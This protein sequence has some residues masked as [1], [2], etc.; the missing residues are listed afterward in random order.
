MIK[1]VSDS[2]C[3][4][5]QAEAKELNVT[6]LPLKILFGE[7]EYYDGVTINHQQFYNMLIES[8][9]FPKT[10]LVSPAAFEEAFNDEDEIICLT[11]TSKLSGTYQS[12]V[13]AADGR[14]NIEVIDSEYVA[15]A[16][17]NLVK[18]ACKLRDEGKSFKEIVEGVKQGIKDTYVVALIETLEYLKKGGR[19][20]A[21]TAAIGSVLSIKPVVTIK[22]GEV[23]IIGKARGSKNATNLLREL[24]K[25]AG[26]IDFDRPYS[27]AYSGLDDTML[28][29]YIVDSADL[30]EG[31]TDSI[32]MG[33]IGSAIGTHAGPGAIAVSFFKK[34]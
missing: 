27:V 26:S 23:A 30:W 33:V 21:A 24:V 1:I 10:S 34:H 18:L 9:E 25:Q 2:G 14:E 6:V 11:V 19:I 17:G 20:S 31:H 13:I 32:P 4:I 29:K 15:L 7:K 28:K 8:D 16:Q 22:D 3:D 5:T 12:A